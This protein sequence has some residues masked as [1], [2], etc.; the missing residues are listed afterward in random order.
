M[1]ANVSY[2]TEEQG[3]DSMFHNCPRIL[4]A[5]DMST[6]RI[7]VKRVFD[8]EYEI[9]EAGNGREVIQLLSSQPF[10]AVLLDIMMPE[11]DGLQVCEHIRKDP[12]LALLPVILVTGLGSPEDVAKGMAAGA[13]DY[14]TKPF[15]IVELRARVRAMVE[16]K[17]LTDRLD[18]TESVLFSLARMVEARDE[19]I[20]D[21]C[22]RLAH[23]G[24]VFGSQLSFSYERLEAL[25]R[26][27]ILHDIGKLAIPDAILL[28]KGK[29]DE[30]EWETMK[31]HT[32]IG[33]ALCAPL[34]NMRETVEIVR[35]HH[36]RWDGSGYPFGLA[37]EDIPLLARVFQ[38]VDIYD[39]LSSERPYKPVFPRG[40]IIAIMR[41]EAMRGW[42]DPKLM[43]EFLRIIESEPQ[44]L[45][46]PLTEEKDR[47]ALI[48]DD[49][50]QS[51]VMD[52]YRRD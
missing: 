25:R 52:W 36:E 50:L 46:L 37:G 7:L 18:D 45:D 2:L 20:G 12:E 3:I 6:N 24:V 40:K 31:Q 33:A 26:G 21:H 51:G 43:A 19:N 14:I 22:D 1:I 49:I 34:K 42:W 8:E 35:C 15:N 32:I 16:R 48:L 30:R 9:V 23:M 38:I 41:E 28:K 10:D 39:A 13:T 11:M 44:V 27:G 4:V 17:R 47:S 5:D 29:L